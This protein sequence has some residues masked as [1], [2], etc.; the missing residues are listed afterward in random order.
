[1]HSVKSL[2]GL[3]KYEIDFGEGLRKQELVAICI[4]QQ[5]EKYTIPEYTIGKDRSNC[6]PELTQHNPCRSYRRPVESC[7]KLAA[8]D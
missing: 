4:R 6:V 2:K 3:K 7:R 1:M 5:N 8:S